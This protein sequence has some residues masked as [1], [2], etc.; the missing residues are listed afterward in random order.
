MRLGS[1]VVSRTALVILSVLGTALGTATDAAERPGTSSYLEGLD[2]L[3]RAAWDQAVA[4][5]T[6]AIEADEENAD[7]YTA[8]GVAYTLRERLT[9]AFSDL[10]RADRLRP[11]HKPTRLWLASVVAMQGRLFEDTKHYPAATPDPYETAVREA[12]RFYG[13]PIFRKDRLR[14]QPSAAQWQQQDAA[15][16]KFPAF[17]R[18][19]VRRVKPAG[20]VSG[21]LKQRGPT[22][23]RWP[24]TKS[25][26][27]G[28]SS[29]SR[30][31]RPGP[32]RWGA[33]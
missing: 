21:A 30:R 33:P 14:E 22:S 17:A 25:V 29:R 2:F 7:Y 11:S 23:A 6:R 24:S 27:C 1:R 31:A 12:A 9:E 18:E 10:S 15:R 20:A 4:A 8:R 5:F 19:F 32:G 26:S 13:D 16:Q 28:T 3:E